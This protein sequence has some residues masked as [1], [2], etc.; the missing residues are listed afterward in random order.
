MCDLHL[1]CVRVHDVLASWGP[2]VTVGHISAIQLCV[3]VCVFRIVQ[4][5]NVFRHFS[6][7]KNIIALIFSSNVHSFIWWNVKVISESTFK[8]DSKTFFFQFPWWHV[9]VFLCIKLECVQ[10]KRLRDTLTDKERETVW[11]LC[12]KRLSRYYSS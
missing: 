4:L 1:F 8:R 10:K 9:L 6:V 3:W 5:K 12:S 2:S 7:Y 11:K